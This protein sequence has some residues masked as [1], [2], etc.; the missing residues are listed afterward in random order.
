[1]IALAAP[2]QRMNRHRLNRAALQYEQFSHLFTNVVEEPFTKSGFDPK[3]PDI[4][5]LNGCLTNAIQHAEKQTQLSLSSVID[6]GW[7][8]TAR[9]TGEEVGGKLFHR[10]LKSSTKSDRR[11]WLENLEGQGTWSAIEA[12]QSH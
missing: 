10:R 6:L 8:R 9:L 2:G 12:R 1:M 7:G 4:N 5:M 3:N 11:S